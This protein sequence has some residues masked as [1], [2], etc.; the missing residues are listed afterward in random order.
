MND[1][2]T[3]IEE[4]KH[5]I[6][7]HLDEYLEIRYPDIIWESMRYTVLLD[8]KRLRPLLVLETVKACGGK[9]ENAIPTACAIEM[10]H[11]QSLIHDDLPCMDNDDLRRGK[12]TNHKVFGEAIATLAGDALLSF[13]PQVIIQ[14]TPTAVKNE[15]I[16]KILEEFL[17]TAGALS[18]IGGQ[19]VDIQSENKKIDKETLNYIHSHKTGDLIR[20]STRAGAIFAEAPENIVKVFDE[21]GRLIGYAF[22]IADDILDIISSADELGKTTGKDE[23]SQKSTYPKLYGLENSITE[24][25]NL[26]KQA[27][28]VLINNNIATPV[29]IQLT[30]NIMIKSEKDK[31]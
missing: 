22:Q 7:K 30:E 1:L 2:K 25:K 9:I 4:N 8:G 3:C 18:L 23:K 5:L 21:F 15:I 19:V 24:V 13:A 27:K 29:L 17:I 6:N 31:K 10:L 26:C 11:A 14:K 12:L 28:N 16:L 20:F